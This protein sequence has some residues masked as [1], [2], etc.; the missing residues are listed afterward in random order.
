MRT[1]HKLD[2]GPPLL[3]GQGSRL[4]R[5]SREVLPL[6]RWWA[7][8]ARVFRGGA[9]RGLRIAG[10]RMGH[11]PRHYVR[12]LV[13]TIRRTCWCDRLLPFF[14]DSEGILA[15]A[16]FCSSVAVFIR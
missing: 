6:S 7:L 11:G 10:R 13:T 15:M 2:T 4:V 14:E 16:R 8:A 9:L 1:S 12:G 5:L 3:G